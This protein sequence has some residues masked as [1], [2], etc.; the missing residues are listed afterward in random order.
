M[1]FFCFNDS[2]IVMIVKV[3][4]KTSLFYLIHSQLS[5][6]GHK[7]RKNGDCLEKIIC[8]DK[9]KGGGKP[10]VPRTRYIDQIN[11]LTGFKLFSS[12]FFPFS[13]RITGMACHC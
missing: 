11:S 13:P 2:Q 12:R 5:Y 1:T 6:F 3:W 7:A 9:L 8:K 4:P 10:G